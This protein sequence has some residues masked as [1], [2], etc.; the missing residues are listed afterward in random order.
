M[1]WLQHPKQSNVD[2][3]NNGKRE[4]S[5]HFRN[6]KKEYLK[7]EIEELETNSKIKYIR[8]FY[9]DISDFKKDYQH[10]TNI[11]KDETSDLDT[12]SLRILARWRNHFSQLFSVRGVKIVR[13]AELHTAEPL[14]SEPSA[15]EVEVAIEKLKRNKSPVLIKSQ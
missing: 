4:A 2:N 12:D 14:V 5:R 8:D 1:Q 15:F 6:K 7:A 3:L 9:M 11:V 13:Q 10:R